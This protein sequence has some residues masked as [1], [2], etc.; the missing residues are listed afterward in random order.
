MTRLL[1]FAFALSLDTFIVSIALGTMGLGR[2]A[3]RNLVLLF[4]FCD[5]A[6]SLVASVLAAR[7]L[8]DVGVLSARVEAS[9]LC[10]YAILIIALGWYAPAAAKPPRD[11]NWLYALPFVLCLDNFM[12]GLSLNTTSVTLLVLAAIVGVSSALMSLVGLQIGS[13]VRTHLPIRVVTLAGAG[14]LC[15]VAAMAL[16]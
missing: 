15:L 16:R 3:K 1:F 9:A 12:S 11:A 2:A 7:W 8:K 14:L 6:A 13:M 10:L 4:A 5:G